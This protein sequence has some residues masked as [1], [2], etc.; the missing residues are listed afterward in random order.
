MFN[1]VEVLGILLYCF[2]DILALF[3]ATS[4]H[5]ILR[6][7]FLPGTALFSVFTQTSVSPE[8]IRLV[9]KIG[10]ELLTAKAVH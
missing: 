9:E 3:S 7:Y 2:K 4:C 6:P 5:H 10:T 8:R 1:R